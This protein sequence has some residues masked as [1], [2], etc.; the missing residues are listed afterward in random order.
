MRLLVVSAALLVASCFGQDCLSRDFGQG[1][2]VCVCNVAHCDK[3]PPLQPVDLGQYV[4]FVSNQEGLR[5]QKK[6]GE[7][8]S[9]DGPTANVIQ[10]GSNTYQTI[11]GFGGAFTDSTGYN[12]KN[13][14]DQLGDTLMR[15]YFAEDGLEYSI[16]RIPIGGTDFS[17]K[18]YSYC[19]TRDDVPDPEL[20]S[21]SLQPEDFEYKI[22][23][24]RQAR[25]L[26]NNSL[27]LFGSA[28]VAPS[29]MKTIPG[30]TSRN[31]SIKYEMYQ[32]WAD[33]L[34][35]FL[36]SYKEQGIDLWGITTGNEPKTALLKEEIPSVAWTPDDMTKWVRE[37]LG[38]ALRKSAHSDI[39]LMLL[40]D[41]IPFMKEMADKV[42][43]DETANGYVDGIATHWYSDWYGADTAGLL[44]AAHESYA[45][46]FMLA[47]EACNGYEKNDIFL[48]SWHRGEKY[49][50]TIIKYFNNWIT[51]FVDWNMALNV[52]GGPTFINNFVD[53]PII[54]NATANEFYK[55][56]MYYAIGHFS[57]AIPKGSIRQEII[58]FSDDVMVTAAARP[59]GGT[60]IVILNKLD[61]VVDVAVRCIGR[62][63]AHIT[64]TP[65][66]LT[67]LVYW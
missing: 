26:R 41:Q 49:A 11:M 57:K 7:F 50:E 31:S 58:P 53:S 47:T 29:W 25:Q 1:G 33:Y 54:V 62:G 59:D 38:P 60:A 6:V 22:P 34:V 4:T 5:F 44:D 23:L 36:D 14:K 15:Q 56:P 43:A 12:I 35:K 13:V 10:L 27:D 51:G 37:N 3:F 24:I 55:Q 45:N 2:T 28:W 18:G 8:I 16:G 42:L 17:F 67:T 20:S 48:G 52:Q 46:K 64:L 65:K 66:S 40:D 39:K 30:F 61:V 32:A 9:D 21:F 19:D 63:D